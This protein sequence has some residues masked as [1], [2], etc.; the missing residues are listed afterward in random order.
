MQIVEILESLWRLYSSENGHFQ[1]GRSSSRSIRR[2]QS[3]GMRG[4]GG[5]V[6]EGKPSKGTG[7]NCH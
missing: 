3:G 2:A 7:W 1:A 6:R 5:G 4:T